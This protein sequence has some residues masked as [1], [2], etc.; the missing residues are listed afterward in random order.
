VLVEVSGTR[1]R[2]EQDPYL[3][4][5]EGSISDDFVRAAT[6][7]GSIAAEIREADT[8]APPGGE[9]IDDAVGRELVG[10]GRP[11]AIDVAR[12]YAYSAIVKVFRMLFEPL[13]EFRGVRSVL[14]W[15][16]V[17]AL[18]VG[19]VWLLRRQGL[20]LVSDLATGRPREARD[21]DWDRVADDA[22]RRGDLR[23]ATR[24]LYHV[25]LRRLA[26]RGIVPPGISTTAGECRAAV[27]A[28][29]PG[30]YDAVARGTSAFE[31]VAYGGAPP[32]P[33][34]VEA[35]REAARRIAA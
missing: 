9:A 26:F 34:D 2:I 22:L 32:S 1:V 28:K 15:A 6:H 21:V 17:A 12:A 24:A 14:S 33:Q 18:L 19:I 25:L 31:R 10:V 16:I 35:L 7:L 13:R 20:G 29:L 3:A 5:L 4:D 27:A 30:A 8:V 11:T 23:E